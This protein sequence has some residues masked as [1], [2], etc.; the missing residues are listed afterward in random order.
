MPCRMHTGQLKWATLSMFANMSPGMVKRNW[1]AT[2]NTDSSG[3]CQRTGRVRQPP[4]HTPSTPA[5]RTCRIT[6][7]TGQLFLACWCAKWQLGPLPSDRPN[8]RRGARLTGV[9]ATPALGGA[10]RHC[11]GAHAQYNAVRGDAAHV[12]EVRKGS[13]NVGVARLLAGLPVTADAVA[14]VVV[15]QDVHLCNDTWAAQ[16]P[17]PAAAHAPAAECSTPLT[18][19]ISCQCL[20]RHKR[21]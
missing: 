20:P 2:R 9:T 18:K 4:A 16:S 7:R 3:H 21:E 12:G 8:L 15:G 5:L 17:A 13:L 11:H 1:T 14:G 6:P 19:G 10:L